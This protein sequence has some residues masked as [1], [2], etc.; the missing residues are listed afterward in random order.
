MTVL[1]SCLVGALAMTSAASTVAV[2]VMV[3][4][5][6]SGTDAHAT[7]GSVHPRLLIEG[8]VSISCTGSGSNELTFQSGSR[9]SGPGSVLFSGCTEAGEPCSS[10]GLSGGTIDATG[11][12]HLVLMGTGATDR[13]LSLFLVNEIHV[14]CPKAVAK[15]FTISGDAAGSIRQKAGSTTQFEISIGTLN[16]EGR[17]QEFSEFENDAGTGVKTAIE[18]HLEGGKGKRAFVETTSS[19]LTFEL[20]TSI[21]K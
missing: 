8:G 6:F 18:V 15:L 13:H 4:P 12:W 10:L 20:T 1:V 16:D 9:N 11:T 5:V 19:T 3:L 21:E 2:A 14:E 7:G 17:I